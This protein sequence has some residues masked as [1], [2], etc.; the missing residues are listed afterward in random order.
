M[1]SRRGGASRAAAAV[2]AVGLVLLLVGC[3]SD[4]G[5]A[6][7]TGEN[8]G[9]EV[10]GGYADQN[11]ASY[12]ACLEDLGL[13]VH[14]VTE[15]GPVKGFAEIENVRLLGDTDTAPI[16][17]DGVDRDAD[18]KGCRAKFPGAKDTLDTSIAID[19]PPETTDDAVVEAGRT[20]AQCARD[21]GF[22]MIAD[23]IVDMIV[24]P[25]EL[26]LDQAVTLGKACSRPLPAPDAAAPRFEYQAAVKDSVTGGMDITPYAQA[27]EGPIYTT[28]VGGPS[29]SAAPSGG[30]TG[31]P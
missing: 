29:A 23:P 6:T 10:A 1:T 15:A 4:D 11:T 24:I 17:V 12:A 2:G 26:S 30:S 21:A 3:A 28:A 16:G 31:T 7:L 8:D 25:Q 13:G 18:I 9:G 27:I 20:W 22:A 14:A 19:V 5:V